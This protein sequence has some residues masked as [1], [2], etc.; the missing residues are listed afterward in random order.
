VADHEHL[1]ENSVFAASV[2]E[3]WR[4]TEDFRVLS[5]QAGNFGDFLISKIVSKNC[6]SKYGDCHVNE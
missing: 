2:S 6:D 5:S 4:R 1:C 3:I